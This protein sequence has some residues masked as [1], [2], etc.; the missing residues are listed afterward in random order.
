MMP[1]IAHAMSPALAEDLTKSLHSFI[2]TTRIRA[3]GMQ[4]GGG[5]LDDQRMDLAGRAGATLS[6]CSSA[7]SNPLTGLTGIE[8]HKM[9]EARQ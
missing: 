8:R 9:R 7:F 1:P 4:A 2:D 3:Q 5:H 6:F